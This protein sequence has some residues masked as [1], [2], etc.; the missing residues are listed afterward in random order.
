MT[1]LRRWLVFAA[2]V[3]LVAACTTTGTASTGAPEPAQP[4]PSASMTV[5]AEF[6]DVVLPANP[7]AA[8]GMYTT[9]VDILITLG[10]PLAKEQ[11]IRGDSGYRTFPSYFP[12]T[13]LAAVTPFANYPDFNYEKILAVQPDFILN[14]LGYDQKTDDR[15]KEI[16]PTFTVNAF[17]GRNWREHFKETAAALGR[18]AQY[19]AWFA[20]YQARLAE[21]KAVI[22]DRA[23]DA[24]VA[25]VSF[26]EGKVAS[27]CYTGLECQTF[28]D[29]GLTIFAPAREKKG[30]GVTLSGENLGR[31]KSVHYAFMTIGAGDTGA[32]EFE[33]TKNTLGRNK[34]WAA[35][36]FV[37]DQR[38]ISYE[39]EMTYGSP[40][41][42]FAFL[43]VIE[44]AFTS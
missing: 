10:Y 15:L 6:G 12:Q 21:V 3:P 16:G 29:L 14:G 38:L 23:K 42:Q 36:P 20:T 1:A 44:K 30:E 19:D 13:E 37:T 34:L 4:A 2:L 40:S 43:D 9:D 7:Q 39:M 28:D 8:L 5:K 11:P 17:D 33:T 27:S 31:L 35:L 41:A 32:K 22:G 26:W 25:P 24:V 18:T